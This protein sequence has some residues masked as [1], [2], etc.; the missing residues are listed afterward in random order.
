M[1]LF[2]STPVGVPKLLDSSASPKRIRPLLAVPASLCTQPD[3]MAVPLTPARA[4]DRLI[5]FRG[6]IRKCVESGVSVRGIHRDLIGRGVTVSYHC[7]WKAIPELMAGPI[8]FGKECDR[9][10]R[11]QRRLKREARKTDS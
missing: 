5:P 8:E 2:I 4:I 11:E 6:E 7:L 10:R 1:K 3:K 9:R